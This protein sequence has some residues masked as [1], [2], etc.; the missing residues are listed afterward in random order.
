MQQN[1]FTVR[2][3]GSLSTHTKS[4]EVFWIPQAE[5]LA[6][7]LAELD[8]SQSAIKRICKQVVLKTLEVD[9]A[10]IRSY[11]A[12]KFKPTTTDFSSSFKNAHLIQKILRKH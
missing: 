9:G 5:I 7:E 2:V 8:I 6:Q 4:L 11:Y 12:A 3:R 1:N 10:M